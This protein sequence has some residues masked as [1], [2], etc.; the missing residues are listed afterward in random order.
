MPATTP[1]NTPGFLDAVMALLR[2]QPGISEVVLGAPSQ[3]TERVTAYVTVGPQRFIAKA[4]N[5]PSGGVIEKWSY[6]FI[7]LACRITDRGPVA[8]AEAVIARFADTWPVALF[9]DRTL[10]GV[11]QDVAIDM[12][13]A[14]EPDYQMRA[15]REWREYPCLIS[16]KQQLTFGT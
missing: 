8:E 15:G 16:G 2:A 1:Y 3:L 10:G 14:R 9:A 6:A 11:V 13:I 12:E 7:V 4:A 5:G